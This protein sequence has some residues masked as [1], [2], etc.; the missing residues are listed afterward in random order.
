MICP[1]CATEMNNSQ[2]C[3]FCG[4]VCSPDEDNT[5]VLNGEVISTG[6]RN[7]WC[8]TT[9]DPHLEGKVV[10]GTHYHPQVSRSQDSHARDSYPAG[11]NIPIQEITFQSDFMPNTPNQGIPDQDI[12]YQHSGIT[13]MQMQTP[14]DDLQRQKT[15]KIA[16]WVLLIFIA[17]GWGLPFLI[18][19]IGFII[20]AIAS[21]FVG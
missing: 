9:D 17:V 8:R 3:P 6:H 4:H 14:G 10:D 5:V 7:R 21:W 1:V 13:G 11:Q 12:T 2:K 20:T 16:R 19:I 15:Y 18:V